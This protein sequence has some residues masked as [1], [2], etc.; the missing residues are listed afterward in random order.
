MNQKKKL[1]VGIESFEKIRREDFYYID[2]TAMIR[3]LL[4]RWAEVNLFTRPRRFGKSLN[5]S[6]LKAF[7][8]IGTDRALFDG[9]EISRETALCEKYL[10]KYPV[11]SI[12][13]KSV[14]G[15]DY[16]SARS[17]LC[18]TI[19]KEALRFYFL[20]DSRRLT[21]QEKGMYRKLIHVDLAK[22]DNFDMSDDVLMGSLGI[23]SGLLKKHYDQKVIILIDEYDVPLAKAS[24]QG[25]YPQMVL[26]IRNLF[27]QALK[28]NDS[29]YFAVL[30]GCLRVAKESI[31][32]GLNN[33][34]V[35]SV[36]AVRFDEYFG[37]TE[38]EVREMLEY[39]DLQD[40]YDAVKEWYDGY[41]FG[42]VDVFC[43]WDVISYCD[44]LTDSP[45]MRPKN[46]WSN[47]SSND[48]VRHFIEKV[49]DGLTKG[50][51]EALIAGE[52]VRK[53]I[54]EELTYL[55]LYDS[56]DNIWSVLFATGYLTQREVSDG[57]EIALCIPNLEIR[58]IYTK[59]IMSMFKEDVSRNGEML[60]DFCRALQA[61]DVEEV[62]RL[63]N[64]YLG[65]TIS[66]RDTFVQ[67]PVKENFYHGILIGILGYKND[68]Y[69]RSNRESGDGYSDILIKDENEETGIIIE[70]KYAEHANYDSVCKRALQQI[71]AERYETEL[72]EEGF[73]T[74]L[75]YGIAC[76]KKKCKVVLDQEGRDTQKR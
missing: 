14:N 24:E 12:S 65:R 16:D 58:S 66:I 55:N 51:I 75:K 31:F 4:H 62:E 17:I 72:K 71:E 6:M 5:M 39:Y 49:G 48:V 25:Y 10:G 1:P 61:G 56:I 32:T 30:T 13:L 64:V 15:A 26:L 70:V 18:T 76:Y 69:V 73:Q 38:K 42:N 27:E 45:M 35:I 22:P 2:K 37:F 21:E 8:E 28:T 46:Y 9:L 47:T 36:T 29:L 60:K 67:K 19:G 53:E 52:S 3:D 59:Q 33:L 7:F 50:E 23:L 54:N 63:L 20:L 34:K 11:I 44:E 40:R 41:R 74:I 57:D 68:W 43:P